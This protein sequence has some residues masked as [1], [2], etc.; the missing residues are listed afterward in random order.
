VEKFSTPLERSTQLVH[1]LWTPDRNRLENL[2][3]A[4]NRL[5]GQ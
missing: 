5:A 4:S 3:G 2:G 1:T